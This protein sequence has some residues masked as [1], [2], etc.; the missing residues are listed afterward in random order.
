ML[1]SMWLKTFRM[2][3]YTYIYTFSSKNYFNKLCAS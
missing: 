2:I 1:M 3:I